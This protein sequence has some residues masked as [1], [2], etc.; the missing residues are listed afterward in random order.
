LNGN[1]CALHLADSYEVVIEHADGHTTDAMLSITPRESG[2]SIVALTDL[3]LRKQF[4]AELE[5]LAHY[6]ALT[7]LANRSLLIERLQ[8]ALFRL[9]RYP[10]RVAVLFI[11][12]DRFKPI[13]DTLGHAVGDRVLIEMGNR[14]QEC[15]RAQDTA[16]RI[17]GDEFVVL[18]ADF[19]SADEALEVADRIAQRMEEPLVLERRTHSVSVSIGIVIN[20]SPDAIPQDLIHN[21]DTAMYE[22]KRRPDVRRVLYTPDMK[23]HPAV[24]ITHQSELRRAF[25]A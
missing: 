23:V 5:R 2:G 17:G 13:N 20:Q 22:A 18:L 24:G 25:D 11:D 16:A 7:G 4:E 10:S 14:I 6:D 19:E 3:T 12:L 1:A 9:R 15:I 8:Q 21:A